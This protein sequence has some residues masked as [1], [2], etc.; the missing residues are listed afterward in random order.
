[1]ENLSY[2][3]EDLE[4]NEK[5]MLVADITTIA[6]K[7]TLDYLAGLDKTD[8]EAILAASAG[9]RLLSADEAC[10][11]LGISRCSLARWVRQGRIPG[12]K[13]QS[14]LFID[15]A[16]LGRAAHRYEHRPKSKATSS[17]PARPPVIPRQQADQDPS[18]MSIVMRKPSRPNEWY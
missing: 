14:K 16:D 7:A 18:A 13:I 15:A 9:N 3:F 4:P 1:M 10:Q 6:V 11:R 12:R 17:A 8:R 2:I 5:K